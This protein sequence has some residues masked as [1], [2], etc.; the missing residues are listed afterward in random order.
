MSNAEIRFA[1]GNEAITEGAIAAGANF[2]PDILSPH[3]Q[4]LLK[5]LQ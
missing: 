3:L 2:T 5:Y 1:M 4:R